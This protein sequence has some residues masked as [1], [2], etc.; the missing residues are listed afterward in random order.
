VNIKLGLSIYNKPWLI[1]PNAALLLLDQFDQVK[2]GK[3]KW[4]SKAQSEEADQPTTYQLTQKLFAKEGIAF[5]PDNIFDMREFKGFDGSKV[6]VIPVDG[7]LMKSNYCGFFGTSMLAELTRLAGKSKTVEPIIFKHDSPGGTVDGTQEFA[8]AVKSSPK[9]TIGFIN[10]MSCSADYWINSASNKIVAGAHTDII[11][12]IGTMISWYDDTAALENRGI[13]LREF[14]ASKSTDKN[15]SFREA[16]KGESKLLVQE[17]LDPIN[18]IFLNAVQS[19]RPQLNKEVLTG[20]TYTADQALE[21]GLIDSI[22]NFE[23]I[24]ND[25]LNATTKSKNTKSVYMSTKTLVF[26][27]VLNATNAEELQLVEGGFL[28]T[29][30]MLNKLDTVLQENE[31]LITSA[32]N[33]LAEANEKA[34]S[35][36]TQLSAA[37]AEIAELKAA[38]EDKSKFFKGAAGKQD[39]APAHENL[40]NNHFAHNKTADEFFA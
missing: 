12:S 23:D 13:V 32:T 20:K 5:A 4:S 3:A 24:L 22:G 34:T 27:N 2:E 6:A 1:E 15:R 11:G 29:E 7:P 19:N 25:T 14:Y 40:N 26:Q 18:N 16:N 38:D 9:K 36:E 30:E 8:D 35:L 21:K 39:P 33:D 10:G 28:L 37:N 31:T 17:M